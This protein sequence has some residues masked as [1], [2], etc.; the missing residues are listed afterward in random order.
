[1]VCTY[2]EHR[3]DDLN[4]CLESI[5]NQTRRPDQVLVVVDHNEALLRRLTTRDGVT[6]IASTGHQGLSGARNTGVEHAV[7]DIVVFIDDDAVAAPE[8]LAELLTPFA[9]ADIAAV[10]GRIDPLWPARRP[11][12]FPPHLDWAIGCSIPTLPEHG[13][14]IRNVFG[15]SAAF[16]RTD[17]IH[18]GGFSSDLGRRG[19][20]AAGCEETDVCIRIRRG[21]ASAEI[22]YA[23][24]SSVRHR[25]THER[26]TVRYVMRRCVAEGRS[27]AMLARR[28]GG[29]AA[30][31]DERSYT[32][33]IGR[34]VLH[35]LA[36][37]PRHPDRAGRAAVLVGGL[38]CASAG[39][40]AER[41]SGLRA[42][43]RERVPA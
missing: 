28:V 2:S 32:L 13:G 42:G 9:H 36:R 26:A 15:A 37:S 14:P 31:G 12:W 35:D 25:V 39:Y 8:W 41:V 43:T 18:A 16:R 27:K 1:V 34:A 33:V 3:L 20:D 7:G 21:R 23:P 17:L 40:V 6:A 29:S 24:R 10:G 30:T 38:A 22:V 19:A 4:A 5:T 11:W